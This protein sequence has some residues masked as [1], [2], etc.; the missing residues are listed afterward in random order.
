MSDA[1]KIAIV[2]GVGKPTGIG[3][4][5]CKKLAQKDFK[6]VL[7]ARKP[8]AARSLADQ[9]NK[10]FTERVVAQPLDIA[11]TDDVDALH[12]MIVNNFGRLDVLIN[13]A[14]AVSLYGERG[15]TA[16]LATAR[17]VLDQGN[18]LKVTERSL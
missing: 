8:E 2:T 1:G 13:S 14:A 16:D 15:E 12:N 9:L 5:L 7:T 10:A 4:E 11:R 3:F 17:A 18:R 6:V